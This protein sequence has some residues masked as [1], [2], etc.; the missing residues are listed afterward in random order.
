MFPFPPVNGNASDRIPEDVSNIF[1]DVNATNQELK[2][3]YARIED[4]GAVRDLITEAGLA[5]PGASSPP[6]AQAGEKV[7]EVIRP[8]ARRCGIQAD[9]A[10]Q[11]SIEPMAVFTNLTGAMAAYQS[12]VNSVDA[13]KRQGRV[14]EFHKGLLS[15]ELT[16]VYTMRS[17]ATALTSISF[18]CP[19]DE[20][21][22]DKDDSRLQLMI[23]KEK[24]AELD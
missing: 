18:V 20:I 2:D 24:E 1:R 4:R 9:D 14:R 16:Y 6:E 5:D 17:V 10:L 21:I 23:V 19:K 13:A 15:S 22:I 11:I 12:L 3:A 8:V 7:V